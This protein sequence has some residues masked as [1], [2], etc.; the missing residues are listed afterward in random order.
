MYIY[1][2]RTFHPTQLSVI[3]IASGIGALKMGCNAE[4]KTVSKVQNEGTTSF[5]I[6]EKFSL[7][8]EA[9]TKWDDYS[10]ESMNPKLSLSG[11]LCGRWK[12]ERGMME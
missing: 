11:S 7:I 9:E 1:C 6:K 3:S 4:S 8:Q 10:L 2:I 5:T 12:G